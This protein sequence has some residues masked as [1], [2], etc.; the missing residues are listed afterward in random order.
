MAMISKGQ[1]W[2]QNIKVCFSIV[3]F[4]ANPDIGCTS[5]K[6]PFVFKDL[7]NLKAQ[8]KEGQTEYLSHLV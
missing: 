2:Q 3:N 5:A 6:F 7:A 8:N 1:S 4:H